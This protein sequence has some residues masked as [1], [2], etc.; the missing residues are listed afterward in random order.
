MAQPQVLRSFFIPLQ[1]GQAILPNSSL[2][3]VLPF[4][5]PLKL[6]N[7]PPWVVG[8]LLWRSL[9]IPLVGLEW[10]IYDT[11][12]GPGSHARIV[13]INTFGKDSRLPHFGIMGT[14]VP[15]LI[16]LERTQIAFDETAESLRPGVLSWVKVN[17]QRA[18]IPDIDAIEAQLVPLMYRA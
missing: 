1:G 3:E 9:N 14:T 12:P 15:R 18:C 13:M 4:A 17:G 8:T 5:A 11:G 10:L 7:A 16:N 6:E 2:V